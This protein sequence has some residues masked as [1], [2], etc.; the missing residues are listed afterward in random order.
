V[1][2]EHAPTGGRRAEGETVSIDRLTREAG[3]QGDGS[4][5][6]A[7]PPWF[8]AAYTDDP[9]AVAVVD[10]AGGR[11]LAANP[12]LA[13][14]LDLAAPGG[15]ALLPAGLAAHEADRR[16]LAAALAT[17]AGATTRVV[18][19]EL[20]VPAGAALRWARARVVSLQ[21][22][23]ALVFLTDVDAQRRADEL[24]QRAVDAASDTFSVLTPIR[25]LTGAVVDYRFRLA[26][27][28]ALAWIGL[29]ASEVI[30]ARF[31]DVVPPEIRGDRI[32][33]YTRVLESLE[34][35]EEL[36]TL[37][38]PEG[39]PVHVLHRVVPFGDAVAV[40]TQD[41]TATVVAEEAE[42]R[43][44]ARLEALVRHSIDAIV[45]GD[46][47]LHPTFASPALEAVV[48]FAAHELPP[49][50]ELVH[51]DDG[52]T[53]ADLLARVRATPGHTEST[54]I[55]LRHR[56]GHWIWAE[57][58]LTN[59]LDDPAVHGIVAHLR[60]I[61]VRHE[62]AESLRR[63][64]LE[65]ERRALH[66][67]LT[68]LP[69][70]TLLLDR[71]D[72][73][74]ARSRR[75]DRTVAVLFCDLDGLKVVNDGLGHLWGDR[76][77]VAAA[78]RLRHALRGIDTVARFGGDEFVVL[79]EDVRGEAEAMRV[80]RKLVAA[81]RRPFEVDDR[82]L[83]T[84]M[85]VGCA[86]AGPSATAESLLSD[87][88]A[89]MYEAKAQG[90]NRA[91][92]FDA[93]MRDGVVRRMEIEHDLHRALARDEL[94]VVYQPAF[95]LATMEI[96]GVEALVRWR[97]PERG[98]L[99]PG[100]FIPVAEDTGL[101]VPLGRQVLERACRQAEEWSRLVPGRTPTVWVNVS[102]R[103]LAQPGFANEIRLLLLRHGLAPERLGLELTESILIE[104]A[105]TSGAGLQAVERLGVRLAVDDFGTGYSSLLYLRHYQVDVIKLDR[106]FVAEL[107]TGAGNDAISA[108]VINLGHTLGMHVTA[109]GVETEAQLLALRRLGCDTACGFLL[110]RPGPA[111]D[112]TRRLPEPIRGAR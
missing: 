6:V 46:E 82:E 86:V 38:G 27:E 18:E 72:H 102:A 85:S 97:H 41:V 31:S 107:G 51:P 66:D 93:S 96:V 55:R 73:A 53:F 54:E 99:T 92:Q 49:S 87:A 52:E 63:N 77:I 26:N 47:H 69:N 109:E 74:L 88:D 45:V 60:D 50:S 25:D 13:S 81:M 36:V 15:G 20:E 106:S 90:R 16:R 32:H 71:I 23:V 30:G 35:L 4:A 110:G 65:L 105:S 98:V 29:G 101:V 8:A 37:P 75:S 17:V 104:E 108:A 94:F 44:E 89:A 10:V 62:Q 111:E 58:L 68:G 57:V 56:S 28:R 11:L 112:L 14:L 79:L 40:T 48:G 9:T 84:T 12:A 76:L 78:A 67:D 19:L 21:P 24:L 3:L 33:D 22:G 100:E 61:T 91:A 95:D 83:F 59:L 43:A 103:Q 64:K 2:A 34:P 1:R 70:R 42:A 80:A 7:A 39:T 5:P